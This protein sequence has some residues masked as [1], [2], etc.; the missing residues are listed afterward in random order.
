[1]G[2]LDS[3]AKF[4]IDQELFEGNTITAVKIYRDATGADMMEAMQKVQEIEDQ[5]K[6]EAPSRF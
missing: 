3:K 1:M 2:E 5:L 6:K 4:D